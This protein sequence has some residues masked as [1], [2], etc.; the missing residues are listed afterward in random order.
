MESIVAAFDLGVS[1]AAVAGTDAAKA[2]GLYRS[3]VKKLVRATRDESVPAAGVQIAAQLASAML[4]RAEAVRH[5]NDDTPQTVSPQS[6]RL[7]PA[8]IESACAAL[9][10]SGLV[11][12]RK[13]EVGCLPTAKLESLRLAAQRLEK[14][15]V[16]FT[17]QSTKHYSFVQFASRCPGRIDVKLLGGVASKSDAGSK[18][19]ALVSKFN[20]QDL[21][22]NGWWRR[23]VD[24]ALGEDC[25]LAYAGL[26]LSQPRSAE[27]PWHTDGLALFPG[28]PA[29]LP[30][31]ALNVFVPLVEV[32]RERGPTQL[33]PG[34][35]KTAPGSCP[36]RAKP[37]DAQGRGARVGERG[38]L[39]GRRRRAC[40]HCRRRDWQALPPS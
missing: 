30:A 10:K 20:V 22:K 7:R 4:L 26:V 33:V 29:M 15:V 39:R 24:A 12:F 31:H 14:F 1:A 9:D 18:F 38:G 13:G 34:S 21:A 6:Q 27:Q 11:I 2:H 36:H 28:A 23:L 16:D 3:A 25:V 32:T 19:D 40:R 17:K 37:A 35:C 5:N 8:E